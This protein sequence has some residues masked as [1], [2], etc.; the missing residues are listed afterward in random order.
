MIIVIC[1]KLALAL[2]VFYKLDLYS[3][4]CRRPCQVKS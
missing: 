3:G 1:M 2:S 4:F